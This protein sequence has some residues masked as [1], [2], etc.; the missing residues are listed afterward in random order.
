[1]SNI[2]EVASRAKLRFE[3][4]KGLLSVEDLWDLPLTH[5]TKANLDQLAGA[6]HRELKQSEDVVSFV[7]PVSTTKLNTTQLKFDVVK[8]IIDIKVGERDAAAQKA[9]R[10]AQK[11]ELLAALAKAEGR[12]LDAKS[13]EELRK[14]IEAFGD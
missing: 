6:L 13:P 11:Q 4:S 2:F 3:T 14:M 12:E 10:S 8:Y 5:E 9:A 1:M 7:K